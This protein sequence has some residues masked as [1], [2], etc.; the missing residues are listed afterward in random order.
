MALR[1]KLHY[2]VGIR[3]SDILSLGRKSSTTCPRG[4][5]RNSARDEG[6]VPTLVWQRT[7]TSASLPTS[8]V[9]SLKADIVPELSRAVGGT[10]TL[11][12]KKSSIPCEAHAV[13]VADSK[14]K[15]LD[16]HVDTHLDADAADREVA[17]LEEER[18]K[19]RA[20]ADV[21]I[22]NRD[23][24]LYGYH[25]GRCLRCNDIRRG[26]QNT[27][28]RHSDECRWRI[29]E[30]YRDAND[31]KSKN[32]QHLFDD[33]KS[34]AAD[35]RASA[36]DLDLNGGL[37]PNLCPLLHLL[38][39]HHCATPKMCRIPMSPNDLECGTRRATWSLNWNL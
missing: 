23:L 6:C 16:E 36:H 30:A 35:P 20:E 17:E 39:I 12:R 3:W 8:T 11:C 25:P 15:H 34:Q 37:Q 10:P 19:Q 5:G 27:W 9:T 14:H 4:Q 22:T 1:H 28:H 26:N 33:S 29:Y 24:R 21:R 31:T 13:Q 7:L 38:Q 18:K 32:V 2:M